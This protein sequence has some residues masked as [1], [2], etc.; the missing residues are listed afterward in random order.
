[1]FVGGGIRTFRI[2]T[3]YVYENIKF[4]LFLIESQYSDTVFMKVSFK[5]LKLKIDIRK[6][7]FSNSKLLQYCQQS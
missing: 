7:D 5:F 1:M 6:I 3:V 4:Q 2:I